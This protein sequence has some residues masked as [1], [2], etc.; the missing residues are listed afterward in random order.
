MLKCDINI[1]HF[2]RLLRPKP[3]L[4]Y[5][6]WF[7]KAYLLYRAGIFISVSLVLSL[8]ITILVFTF[9]CAFIRIHAFHLSQ[10]KYIAH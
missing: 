5:D 9:V 6:D 8:A 4:R 7:R 10:N 2:S 1:L 3:R